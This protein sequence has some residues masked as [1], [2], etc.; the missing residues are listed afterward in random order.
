MRD[1]GSAIILVLMAVVFLGAAFTVLMIDW[2]WVD[3]HAKESDHNIRLKIPIPLNLVTFAMNFV[4]LEETGV[5]IPKE[6]WE[7]RELIIESLQAIAD[8]PDAILVQVQTPEAIV[9]VEK[10]GKRILFNVEAEDATV[11]GSFPVK[12]LIEM[13]EKWDWK[14]VEPKMTTDD[15]SARNPGILFSEYVKVK[16]PA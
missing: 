7:N 11:R 5:E 10:K 15:I 4:P 8:C 3:I 16:I 2:A 9:L 13:I 6:V 14:Y 12:P 1:R